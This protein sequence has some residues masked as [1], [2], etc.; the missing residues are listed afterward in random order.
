[1][2]RE[3]CLRLAPRTRAD[4]ADQ[5]ACCT[6]LSLPE[7]YGR[8]C[9][10]LCVRVC[11]CVCVFVRACACVCVSVCGSSCRTMFVD[12]D[13]DLDSHSH[14]CALIFALRVTP[15]GACQRGDSPR[16]VARRTQDGTRAE[17]CPLVSCARELA[18]HSYPRG[19]FRVVCAGQRH[20]TNL[21]AP[22]EPLNWNACA[23]LVLPSPAPPRVCCV[24][25]SLPTGMSARRPESSLL[26]WANAAPPK[27]Y[28]AAKAPAPR[29]ELRS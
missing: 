28:G 3:S 4:H 12:Q 15:H 22:R 16:T 8:A 23:G 20:G 11:V 2:S 25:Q 6:F 5:R 27:T 24:S 26:A 7:S 18:C 10:C 17:F 9:V 1:M 13:D 19:L 21:Y 14:R 29:M